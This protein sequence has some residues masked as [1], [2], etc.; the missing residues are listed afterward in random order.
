MIAELGLCVRDS[1]RSEA[2]STLWK[3][4]AIAK[5]IIVHRD[6]R[7]IVASNEHRPR[8]STDEKRRTINR[9]TNDIEG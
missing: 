3:C 2:L 5:Q 8:Q 1:L 4:A 6:T 7:A 9:G